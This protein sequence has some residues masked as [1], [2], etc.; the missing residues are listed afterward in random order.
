MV[1]CVSSIYSK[2]FRLEFN[3]IKKGVLSSRR[4][5]PKSLFPV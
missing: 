2:D 5:E 3:I 4:G 1:S